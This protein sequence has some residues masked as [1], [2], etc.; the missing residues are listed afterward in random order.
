MATYK[1]T[2]SHCCMFSAPVVLL[3][4][5]SFL[6]RQNSRHPGFDPSAALQPSALIQTFL[7]QL[8]VHP[9]MLS[10][11]SYK[12]LDYF[13]LSPHHRPNRSCMR[14]DK[15]MRLA[16]WLSR[17]ERE[18][19]RGTCGGRLRAAVTTEDSQQQQRL[20][21]TFVS[22]M[23]SIPLSFLWAKATTLW[24]SRHLKQ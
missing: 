23:P 6:S 7:M 15:R 16:V 8:P 5:G 11:P 1:I 13:Y 3:W 4:A 18:Q 20:L 2:T 19:Q 9:P 17:K 14:Q 10:F 24:E 12:L 22:S 21:S